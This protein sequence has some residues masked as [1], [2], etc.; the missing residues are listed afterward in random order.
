MAWLAGKRKASRYGVNGASSDATSHVSSQPL[1]H[2]LPTQSGI[3]QAQEAGAQVAS[4]HLQSDISIANPIV[5]SRIGVLKSYVQHELRE[6]GTKTTRGQPTPNHS[7]EAEATHGASISSSAGLMQHRPMTVAIKELLRVCWSS[8]QPQ[9][10]TKT[11]TDAV[12]LWTSHRLLHPDSRFRG[13]W[14]V[15]TSVL[16]M[17]SVSK[18]ITHSR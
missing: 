14:D 2:E 9:A 15:L 11:S 8:E 18:P 7:L 17:Y 13:Y 3:V 16:I 5:S 4:T 12:S 10:S 1:A 6:H